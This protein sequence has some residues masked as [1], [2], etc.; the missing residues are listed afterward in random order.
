MSAEKTR[1]FESEPA[2]GQTPDPWPGTSIMLRHFP[3]G[4]VAATSRGR[5]AIGANEREALRRLALAFSDGPP[6]GS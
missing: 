1:L 2:T 6:V 3:D 4:L 5:V